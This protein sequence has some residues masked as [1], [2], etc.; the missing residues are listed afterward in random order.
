MVKDGVTF[1]VECKA[2]KS[3]IDDKFVLKW[4]TENVPFTRKWLIDNEKSEKTEFQ[5]W[6]VG[7]FTDSALQ[8][9]NKAEAE[10]SKY[11][12]K[13]YDRQQML[14]LAK[15]KNDKH[16]LEIMKNHFSTGLL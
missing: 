14:D 2:T 11:C 13:H 16:F 4:L 5:I 8:L 7:G 1:I 15:E 9:L 12:I 10:T 6:S 3:A